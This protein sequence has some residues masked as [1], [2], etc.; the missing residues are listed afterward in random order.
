MKRIILTESQYKRLVRKPLNETTIYEN[1]DDVKKLTKKQLDILIWIAGGIYSDFE[2]KPDLYI[3]KIDSGGIYINKDKYNEEEKE[4]IV[5]WAEKVLEEPNRIDEEKLIIYIDEDEPEVVI[6]EPE[7][8]IDE[9]EGDI[10]YD[11][12][13]RYSR[14]E[15]INLFKNISIT[16]MNR[17]NIPASITLAQGIIESGNGNSKLARNGK[18]H[19]GIKCWGWTGDKS[20]HDDDRPNECFRNYDKVEESYE[21]HSKF[22]KKYSRYDSLFDLDVTDYK[23]WA[24]G[25]KKA[26]YATSPDYA[27]TLISIIES[28]GL[29]RFDKKSNNITKNNDNKNTI[30]IGG[31]NDCPSIVEIK[32]NNKLPSKF[33]K[34]PVGNNVYRSN[35][36]TLGQLK[37]I[38]KNY[39][40]NT[41]IRMN[42]EEGTKV[43]PKCEKGLVEGMNKE[44]I[45]DP[46]GKYLYVQ[47]HF[48]EGNSFG[49][50]G[51]ET[52]EGYVNSLK[53]VQPILEKGNVLIHCTAGADRT[54]YQV[55]RF[56]KDNGYCGNPNS[57]ECRESLW[58]YTT[59]YNHW[60]S[61]ISQGK[62]GYI[63]YMEAFYP[64]EL[65][66]EEIGK[67]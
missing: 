25:L 29:W 17:Y 30:E 55:A 8:V 33:A 35:Q 31:S 54:G 44:Y 58:Y 67:K 64:Y 21:D 1:P 66:K 45:V 42:A 27:N 4:S 9:P 10:H 13:K 50:R 47:A 6:D 60:E 14:S 41:V 34:V 19:F 23:G 46:T 52:G 53:V 22:L 36:P 7:V 18:N 20:Y 39:N 48:N 59:K 16:Q 38:L 3:K 12:T 11:I 62:I 28:N 26:G 65:W 32:E 51:Y 43:E 5:S 40:I 24:K 49:G 56:M 37:Y 57:R 61:Y 2:Y 63:R 15:Y